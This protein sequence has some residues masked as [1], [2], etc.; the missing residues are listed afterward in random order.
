[1][2]ATVTVREVF[3][4]ASALLQDTDPQFARS[5]ERQMVDFLNEGALFISSLLPMANSRIDTIRVKPGSL[6][7][8]ETVAQAD[9]IPGDGVPLTQPLRG[10]QVLRAICNMGSDGL[11]PGR[12]IR[13]VPAEIKDAMNLFWRTPGAPEIDQI[14]I[15][16]NTPKYFEFS[17]AL[18]VPVWVRMAWT[19]QPTPVPYTGTPLAP[20]YGVNG[21]DN[22]AIPL[23]DEYATVLTNWIVARSNMRDTEWADRNKGDYFA[24]QVV[25]WLNAKVTATAGANPNLE[26]LPF[27]P[28][29]LGQAA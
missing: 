3:R 18:S 5:P 6:Q 16:P 13:V 2:A 22:L 10:I 11:T 23:G 12:T 17:P 15:D 4:Q 21:T 24:Q 28:Q 1:V 25:S 8:I 26:T 29:P 19:V 14:C 20:Q 27:Q 7:S 9:V